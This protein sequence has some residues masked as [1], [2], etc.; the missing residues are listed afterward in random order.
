MIHTSFSQLGKFVNL[1]KK[2]SEDT[3]KPNVDLLN[4]KSSE[5]ENNVKTLKAL[6]YDITDNL[7]LVSIPDDL[8][9]WEVQNNLN[10]RLMGNRIYY[11]DEV[12]STQDIA[13]EMAT[14]PLENG[15]VIIAKT[16]THSR[17][18]QD[19]QWISPPGGIWMSII[20][21]PNFEPI[22]ST[23]VPACISLAIAN[24]IQSIIGISVNLK[25][26]NDIMIG[27]KKVA[28]ILIDSVMAQEIISYMV[29]GI[30][31]NL[32]VNAKEISKNMSESVDVASL[33]YS[34]SRIEFIQSILRNIEFTFNMIGKDH[35]KI[36]ND[37][38]G[39]SSTIGKMVTVTTL[40]STI[41]G[42]ALRLD[43]D[44]ALVISNDSIHRVLSG[45]LT[46]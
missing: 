23:L 24:A 12:K 21:K 41:T 30:G 11:M 43:P 1:L 42:K 13:I 36:I 7:T 35:D 6:G 39:L 31:I 32:N 5:I 33:N 2:N 4:L 46:F 26:P 45:S 20:I 18:R 29:I 37:W 17:G 34:G 40:Q 14:N 9:P 22:N 38:T 28:G 15:T 25:W 19:K 44:G 27:D 10:T 16:Q 3:V 8:L